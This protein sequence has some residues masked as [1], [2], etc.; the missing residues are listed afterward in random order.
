MSANNDGSCKIHWSGSD[1]EK[2]KYGLQEDSFAM[3]YHS[4]GYVEY[5]RHKVYPKKDPSV[6]AGKLSTFRDYLT[7][8]NLSSVKAG[9]DIPAFLSYEY[10]HFD[11]I[12]IIANV[13]EDWIFEQMEYESD[14]R[15]EKLKIINEGVKVYVKELFNTPQKSTSD[16]KTNIKKEPS[17]LHTYS[18]PQI[19]IAYCLLGISIN[20][21][22]A[23]NI[24]TKHSNLKSWKKL[25]QKRITKKSD[26]TKL[27]R[28]K[29][30]DTKHKKNLMAAKRLVSG[31]NNKSAMDELDRI[32][33]AFDAN[34]K[35]E[36]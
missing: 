29:T 27:S 19:A 21:E 31:I 17:V 8:G 25:V 1:L 30:S 24:L 13:L 3:S 2:I 28:N 6:F 36:Y 23:E 5:Y 7:S 16:K 32:I 12:K 26:L 11:D 14:I 22:N 20:D 10:L 33:A 4:D 34:F 15:K 9:K 35:A 18:H